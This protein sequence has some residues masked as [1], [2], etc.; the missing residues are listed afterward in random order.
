MFTCTRTICIVTPDKA[1]SE[2]QLFLPYSSMVSAAQSLMQ[3]VKA[4]RAEAVST[5][6]MYQARVSRM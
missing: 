1:T 3:Q 5:A 4:A 6:D 2:R